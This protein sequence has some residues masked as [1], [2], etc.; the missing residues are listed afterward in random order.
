[1]WSPDTDAG[2]LQAKYKQAKSE[3][4]SAQTALQNEVTKLRKDNL[5]LQLRLR[6]IEVANDDYERKDRI[7]KSS[8]EEMETNYHIYLEKSIIQ[9]EQIQAGEE[10]RE[11]LRIEEQRLR[12]ELSDLKV[13]QEIT[14][15][16]LNNALAMAAKFGN[17]SLHH[18]PPPT[19]FHS[20]LSETSSVTTDSP[21]TPITHATSASHSI[22]STPPSPPMS[23][24]S[25]TPSHSSR[26]SKPLDDPAA[27]PRPIRYQ[28]KTL[29][30]PRASISNGSAL[31]QPSRPPQ[32]NAS[33]S[34][35]HVRGLIG[36]M[37]RLEQRVQYARSNL[38]GA[39]GIHTPPRALPRPPSQTP[40]NLVGSTASIRSMKKPRPTST[41]STTSSVTDYEERSLPGGFTSNHR[42]SFGAGMIERPGSR[43]SRGHPERPLS[44][45]SERPLSRT[46]ERPMSRTSLSRPQSR[47]SLAGPVESKI[48][49]R[50]QSRVSG[51]QTPV[52]SGYYNGYAAPPEYDL[53][54]TIKKTT[55]GD[56]RSAGWQ[57]GIGEEVAAV[58][59]TPSPGMIGRRSTVGKESGIPGPGLSAL[60]RPR[61]SIGG[62]GGVSGVP[63]STR[64]VS[65]ARGGK[66][67]SLGGVGETY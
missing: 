28:Q 39:N 33:R 24:V 11:K 56:R 50:P 52:S 30:K 16:K 48:P 8:L 49:Q 64:R 13:E 66:K 45:T 55:A 59:K 57:N 42:M 6:D 38:P 60:P 32:Q 34:L 22:N 58:Q 62:G 29:R 46:S 23:E 18:I 26:I 44:R 9:Q 43:L 4:N 25:T 53:N 7:V 37:Q 51:R 36:Q 27:T 14:I 1:M 41:S 54:R 63:V 65:I 10:E 35:N 12:D 5:E 47:T 61:G 20:P 31:P 15:E 67:P 2:Y 40:P 17:G 3:A 21:S 19:T